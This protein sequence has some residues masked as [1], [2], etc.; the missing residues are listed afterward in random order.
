MIWQI[1]IK[2]LN[3]KHKKAFGFPKGFLTF[4][5]KKTDKAYLNPNMSSEEISRHLQ[6]LAK[7]ASDG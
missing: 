1:K 7:V 6:S 2:K 4:A 3:K 5:P